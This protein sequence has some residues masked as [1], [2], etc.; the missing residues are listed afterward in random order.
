MYRLYCA[1]NVNHSWLSAQ[2]QPPPGTG[3]RQ[4]PKYYILY[5][6]IIHILYR[7][8][9]FANNVNHSLL[10]AQHQPPPGSRPA[11]TKIPA[12]QRNLRPGCTKVNITITSMKYKRLE[13][14]RLLNFLSAFRA[15]EH[16]CAIS[17]KSLIGFGNQRNFLC[18]TKQNGFICLLGR[19]FENAQKKTPTISIFIY[20]QK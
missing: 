7:L 16:F 9:I 12:L 1:N 20:L 17:P 6:Y 15:D 11:G 14:L 5:I 18:K 19:T 3:S 4:A 2:H 10:S 8:H 13:A